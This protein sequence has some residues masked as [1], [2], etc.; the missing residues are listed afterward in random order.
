[1]HTIASLRK[2]LGLSTTNQVRNRIEA[3][4]DVLDPYL[5]RGPNNQILVTEEGLSL[6]RQMQE[7]LDSGLKMTEASEIIKETSLK[8]D[9]IPF[10]VSSRIGSNQAIQDEATQRLIYA[11]QDEIDFLRGRVAELESR[12]SPPSPATGSAASAWWER[13]RE[14]LDA[15]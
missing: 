2:T 7:L 10:R 12:L 4:R 3:I 9:T 6:L 15:A 13:L 14:D 1:M 8:K 5:R 11:L